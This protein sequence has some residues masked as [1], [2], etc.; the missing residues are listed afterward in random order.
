[1][2]KDFSLFCF[3]SEL[4]FQDD[5]HTRFRLLL[6]GLPSSLFRL[7]MVISMEILSIIMKIF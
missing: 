2:N 1:M 4:F 6:L 7:T 5:S 3:C